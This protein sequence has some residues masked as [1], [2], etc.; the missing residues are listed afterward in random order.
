[1]TEIDD[2]IRTGLD[3]DDRA[4]LASLD[5]RRGLFAQMGDSFS[6]PLGGWAKLVFALTFVLS[7]VMLYTVW[8]MFAAEE[9][10]EVVLWA[11]ATLVLVMSVG[12]LKDWLF[13][14]MNMFFVLREVK[15]LQ[16]QVALLA[17]EE[18]KA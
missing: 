12:F 17:G 16:V 10:R 3:A 9:L 6:G 18:L 7:F 8:R 14:R 2:R 13:S 4:F 1:M 15:R 5:H 11:T